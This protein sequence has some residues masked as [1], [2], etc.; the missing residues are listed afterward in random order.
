MV[1]P[2]KFLKYYTIATKIG[3]VFMPNRQIFD[4]LVFTGDPRLDIALLS[5]FF[6]QWNVQEDGF[7]NFYLGGGNS[8]IHFGDTLY[9]KLSGHQLPTITGDGF[10][11]IDVKRVVKGLKKYE[12]QCRT[13]LKGDYTQDFSS[14]IQLDDLVSKLFTDANSSG[15]EPSVETGLHAQLSGTNHRPRWNMHDHN[16]IA[17]GLL[18]SNNA[19]EAFCEIFAPDNTFCFIPFIEPGAPLSIKF[20]QCMEG[21]RKKQPSVIMMAQHGKIQTAYSPKEV[22]ELAELTTSKIKGYA[23]SKLP[24]SPFHVR[25]YNPPS[26]YLCQSIQYRLMECFNELSYFQAHVPEDDLILRML[27]SQKA[28]NTIETGMPNPDAAVYGGAAPMIVRVKPS[29]GISKLKDSIKKAKEDYIRQYTE[30]TPLNAD[31]SIYLPKIVLVEGICAVTMGQN[32]K[33]VKNA[34]A[35]LLDTVYVMHM[36]QAFGGMKPLSYKHLYYINNWGA[37]KRRARL[38]EKR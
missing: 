5:R 27:N 19:E 38:A 20:N 32:L 7:Q 25:S 22:W 14:V 30:A 12:E 21:W 37:E 34:Y 4:G 28:L 10:G 16:T 9:V 6:G 2:E 29:E 15:G 1:K 23:E 17:N 35:S 8:S 18:C 31:K 13:V 33:Q 11:K 36:A 3:G 24:R 26:D